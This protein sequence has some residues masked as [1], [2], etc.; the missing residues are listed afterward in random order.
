M[1]AERDRMTEYPESARIRAAGLGH[2][3]A[4][5]GPRTAAHTHPERGGRSTGRSRRGV[6]G[7]PPHP[8]AGLSSALARVQDQE[9]SIDSNRDS[10]A[11]EQG[12]KNRKIL[13]ACMHASC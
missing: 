2:R 12:W 7:E 11:S 4:F 6:F 13:D 10:N 8:D 3:A 9:P 1:A 5:G